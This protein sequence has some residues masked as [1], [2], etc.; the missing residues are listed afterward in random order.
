MCV[1]LRRGQISSIANIVRVYRILCVCYSVFFKKLMRLPCHALPPNAM[2]VAY[3]SRCA[4]TQMTV[5]VVFVYME[6]FLSPRAQCHYGCYT[7]EDC[8][9][10]QMRMPAFRIFVFTITRAH[11]LHTTAHLV[12]A[13]LF[14]AL[15]ARPAVSQIQISGF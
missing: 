1:C 7:W 10:H 8:S 13:S 5:H 9:E 4:E 12:G 15:S 14:A 2:D 11:Q 6:T 3:R